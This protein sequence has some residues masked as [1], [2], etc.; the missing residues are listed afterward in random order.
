MH[1]PD[2][3]AALHEAH[4]R[5][6]VL[7]GQWLASEAYRALRGRF[8]QV[9]VGNA[10]AAATAAEQLLA[11]LEWLEDLLAPLFAA[12]AGDDLFEPPLRFHRDPLRTGVILLD[13]PAVSLSATVTSA[14]AMATLPSP[15]SVVVPGRLTVVR[16][17]RAGGARLRRWQ[18]GP[19]VEPFSAATAAPCRPL[20][21]VSLADGVVMRCD[22]REQGA[23]LAG[24]TRDIVTLTAAI[25][26]DAAPLMREY[27]LPG[28][29]L[30]RAATLDDGVSRTAM[31]LT[32][33]RLGGR[34]DAGDVFEAATHDA[35]FHLR[36]TAMREWLALDVAAALP[37]LRAMA[38]SDPDPAV[39]AAACATSRLAEARIGERIAA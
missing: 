34:H 25:R 6:H 9:P 39:R 14:D 29:A 22:G 24:A 11:D 33:L 20:A 27:A 16:Y 36:W 23:L 10:E 13:H 17:H 31:L 12:L 2:D 26:A 4:A 28:G 21:D 3:P 35:A 37:R 7:A 5:S 18:A 32:L 15:A 1:W 19:I 30:L 38:T 8:D